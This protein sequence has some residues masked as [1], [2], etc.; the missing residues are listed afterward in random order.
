MQSVTM[1]ST[2]NRLPWFCLTLIVLIYGV[3]G[4]SLFTDDLPRLAVAVA[5]VGI[6]ALAGTSR[7]SAQAGFDVWGGVLALTFGTVFILVGVLISS[8]AYAWAFAV[9]CVWAF[10]F[11][12]DL[13]LVRAVNVMDSVGFTPTQIFWILVM[14]S[15]LSVA[16]GWVTHKI[17]LSF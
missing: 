6:F 2:V 10:G 17:L 1:Q 8:G 7:F 14:I 11:A 12:L 5:A 15:S 3:I 4:W 16:L 13:A 9:A